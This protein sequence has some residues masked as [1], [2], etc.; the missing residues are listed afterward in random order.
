MNAGGPEISGDHSFPGL[1]GLPFP[2]K[3]DYHTPLCLFIQ[4]IPECGYTNVIFVI[5]KM[6]SSF[7]FLVE[8]STSN[9]LTGHSLV[10]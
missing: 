6:M 2:T 3:T 9:K 1:R 5:Q 8:F 10:I 4:T 7:I